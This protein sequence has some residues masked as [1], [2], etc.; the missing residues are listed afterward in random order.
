MARL[1]PLAQVPIAG[2][3]PAFEERVRH[4]P[5]PEQDRLL[6]E[7]DLLRVEEDD[8]SSWRALTVY[9]ALAER[10]AEGGPI[11]LDRAAWTCREDPAR[12]AI[13]ARI[14]TLALEHPGEDEQV[15][16]GCTLAV[17]EWL[18]GDFTGAER[19]LKELLP[20]VRGREDRLELQVYYGLA[21]LYSWQRRE[22]ESLGLASQQQ[23]DNVT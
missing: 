14:A 21:S 3:D 8:A 6:A 1:P 18:A 4:A 2:L 7:A 13:Q 10:L 5:R 15:D 17:C 16:A 22:L 9:R 19:R 11:H 12:D 23:A 20:R